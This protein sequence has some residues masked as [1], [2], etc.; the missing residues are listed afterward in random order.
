MENKK[1]SAG[2]LTN[3]GL[4]GASLGG[5]MREKYWS[6]ITSDEK[7]ER[8]RNQVKML[9]DKVSGLE[10]ALYIIR[11]TF[12]NHAHTENKIV[13]YIQ[14]FESHLDKPWGSIGRYDGN[15]TYF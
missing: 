11:K 15:E 12:L 3:Q 14:D 2:T 10:E 5:A 7:V 13:Q 9:Q 1:S 8:M 4:V 6:E